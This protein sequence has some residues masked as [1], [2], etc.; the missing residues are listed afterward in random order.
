MAFVLHRCNITTGL[1]IVGDLGDLIGVTIEPS[2]LPQQL[3]D[4]HPL[5]VKIPQLASRTH[6]S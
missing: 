1:Q 3:R 6:G 4:I 5:L 2:L